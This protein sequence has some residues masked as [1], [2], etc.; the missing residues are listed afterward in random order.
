MNELIFKSVR[1]NETKAV[2]IW[3]PEEE[4]AIR[5]IGYRI[6]GVGTVA[7]DRIIV[8]EFLMG[9]TALP[10]R[11]IIPITNIKDTLSH[12]LPVISLDTGYPL[13]V[14]QSLRIRISDALLHGFID[15]LV[16]GREE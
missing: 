15:V 12:M 13:D 2:E 6:H 9:T 7:H 14:N 3:K 16:W 4:K 8:A 1:V 5:L 10:F 11:Q